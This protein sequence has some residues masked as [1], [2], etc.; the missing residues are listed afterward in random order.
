M[1]SFILIFLMIST[2]AYAQTTQTQQQPPS[3]ATPEFRQFDFWI[4]EWNVD[5]AGKPAGTSSIQLI[6]DKCV[7]LENWTGKGGYSGKSFNLY[8]A[9]SKQWNQYWVDNTGTAIVFKGEFKDG[10][11]RMQS[12]GK[13]AQGK[14]QVS[15]MIFTPVAANRVRQVWEQSDDDGKTW[16]TLFDGNYVR[17]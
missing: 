7:I 15:R 1:K 10:S 11:I 13:N 2:F 12:E 3:C 17:K 4:G 6:L 16:K 8:N 14:R 9:A 5:Q